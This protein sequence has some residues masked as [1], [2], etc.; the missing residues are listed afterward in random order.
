MMEQW[1]FGLPFA[2]V[3]LLLKSLRLKFFVWSW[4]A[5]AARANL[6]VFAKFT[7]YV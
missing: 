1:A 4:A 7:A 6:V 5:D 2:D 3:M